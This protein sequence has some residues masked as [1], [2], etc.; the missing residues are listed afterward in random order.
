MSSST[1]PSMITS[2]RFE[3]AADGVALLIIDVPGRSMNVFTP[4]FTADLESLIAQIAERADIRGAVVTSGKSN[5][6]MAGADLT[7][8]VGV[9]ARGLSPA[10][11]AAMVA[12]SAKAL[13]ALERCGKPVVAA[14]NGLALGGGFEL[15]LACHHRVLLEERR[16]V[17]GLPEVSVGLLP[18]GGGTQRLPR[19]IGIERALPLLLTGR[20][21]SPQEALSFGLV[22]ALAP[23]PEALLATARRW[24]LE[25]ADAKQPWDLKGF[26]VPG[27]SGALAAHASQSFGV[28]LAQV[29]RDTHDNYPAPLSI[30]SAVYEGTQLPIDLGLQIEAQYFGQL[31]AGPVARNLMRTMFINR[32]AATKRG[33]GTI[34]LNAAYVERL[35]NAYREEG[36]AMLRECVP[37]PLIAN[38]SRQAGFAE[39][40]LAPD[41]VSSAA[42]TSRPSPQRLDQ[43]LLIVL[44][45]EAVRCL[46]Q[47]VVADAAEADLHAV[48]GFGY[49]SWTGGPL[50]YIET[51]GQNAFVAQC[52]ALAALHGDRFQPPAILRDR[53]EAGTSF[54][55]STGAAPLQRIQ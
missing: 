54:H 48:F 8:F 7:D 41:A 10:E 52:D 35:R 39:G 32:G 14:I 25:H 55:I 27:G 19:L 20:H 36:L 9:H 3:V 40:P 42:A 21:V 51:L 28:T 34:T 5:A 33:G 15:C 30:L 53:P 37:T 47:D 1:V 13:R 18:G 45:L 2:I 46:Q 4:G 6:F 49:P 43:R 24:V 22:D 50:S 23:T 17:V 12:P 16:V 11:A 31:L 29:R 38:A 26:K 44:A